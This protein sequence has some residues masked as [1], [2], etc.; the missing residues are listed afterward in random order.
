MTGRKR[1]VGRAR[2]VVKYK[3]MKR[4]FYGEIYPVL[5]STNYFIRIGNCGDDTY[6]W[7]TKWFEQ[8]EEPK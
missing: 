5:A 1:I 3:K 6:W 2:C 4:I 7:S 8:V